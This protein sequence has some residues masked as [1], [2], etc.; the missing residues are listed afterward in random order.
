M[1]ACLC[2][3]EIMIKLYN[4]NS[5]FFSINADFLNLKSDFFIKKSE[6]FI[7]IA[8]MRGRKNKRSHKTN[9]GPHFSIAY[10]RIRR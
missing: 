6:F 8:Y 1:L 4:Y 7:K 10:M 2:K 5:Y 9:F 3:E